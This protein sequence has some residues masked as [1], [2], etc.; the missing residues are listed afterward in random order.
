MWWLLSSCASVCTTRVVYLLCGCVAVWRVVLAVIVLQ[1]YVRLKI[2]R[3]LMCAVCP[4]SRAWFLDMI[5]KGSKSSRHV[6]SRHVWYGM[7]WYGI[8][9]F[10]MYS[11]VFGRL[12]IKGWPGQARTC[13]FICCTNKGFMFLRSVWYAFFR[14]E[15]DVANSSCGS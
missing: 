5:Y 13:G 9:L 1:V 4:N 8:R 2:W 3:D 11:G 12:E 10:H 14:Q 7:V 15:R 6:T